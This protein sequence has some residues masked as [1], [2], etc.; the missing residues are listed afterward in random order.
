MAYLAQRLIIF[1]HKLADSLS[2]KWYK[3][4]SV[5][6]GYVRSRLS[7]ASVIV[8]GGS[9]TKWRSL[10]LIDGTAIVEI[11][12]EFTPLCFSVDGML[13][14]EADFFMH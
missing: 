7:V 9:R 2:T 12:A 4:Y 5:V 10:G 3:S 13:G 14:T 11:R 6:M 1:L 8:C